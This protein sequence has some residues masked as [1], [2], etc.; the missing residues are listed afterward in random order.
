[1]TDSIE[2][3][4]EVFK[5]EQPKKSVKMLRGGALKWIETILIYSY[6]YKQNAICRK[7]KTLTELI[8]RKHTA[9][10]IEIIALKRLFSSRSAKS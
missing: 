1:M 3:S 4:A 9:S 6:I 10:R 8:K 2:R 5:E 7:K